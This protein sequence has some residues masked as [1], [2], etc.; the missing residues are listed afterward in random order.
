[1]NG[2]ASGTTLPGS[3]TNFCS[4]KAP[5]CK[6]N[7]FDTVT[8][9]V[10][11]LPMVIE[12]VEGSKTGVPQLTPVKLGA[13]SVNVTVA[14]VGMPEITVGVAPAT[15]LTAVEAPPLTL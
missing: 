7:G 14:P 1:M 6:V 9:M 12:A 3:L 13:S 11:P 10:V 4:E 15:R 8:G 2:V 5:V